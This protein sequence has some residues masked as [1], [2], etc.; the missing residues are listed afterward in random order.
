[1]NIS[2]SGASRLPVGETRRLGMGIVRTLARGAG[3]GLCLGVAGGSGAGQAGQMGKLPG[4]V[5]EQPAVR[6][7]PKTLPS[8]V[9]QPILMRITQIKPQ[10]VLRGG[11]VRITGH[12]FGEAQGQQRARIG[13][14]AITVQRW[15]KELITGTLPGRLSPGQSY[16]V[17]VVDGQGKTLASGRTTACALPAQ[18]QVSPADRTAGSSAGERSSPSVASPPVSEAAR[19]SPPRPPRVDGKALLEEIKERNQPHIGRRPQPMTG[20]ATRPAAVLPSQPGLLQPQPPAP[21]L[22]GVQRPGFSQPSLTPQ[23]E[24]GVGAAPRNI[25]PSPNQT[26]GFGEAA[27]RMKQ[28]QEGAQRAAARPLVGGAELHIN[29]SVGPIVEV[30]AGDPVNVG[31]ST[32]TQIGERVDRLWLVVRESAVPASVCDGNP[33]RSYPPIPAILGDGVLNPPGVT[34]SNPLTRLTPGTAYHIRLCIRTDLPGE[35][36]AWRGVSNP[37]TLNY[38]RLEIEPGTVLGGVPATVVPAPDRGAEVRIN[39]SAGPAVEV[40]AGDPVN[41]S[42]R[43]VTGTYELIDRLWLVV[44]ESALP[45]DACKGNPE[46]TYKESPAINGDGAQSPPIRIGRNTLTGFAP[47]TT[48]YLRLCVRTDQRSPDAGFAWRLFSN[49]LTL[50]YPPAGTPL[51][52]APV[53]AT[54]SL[55]ALKKQQRGGI[56]IDETTTPTCFGQPATIVGTPGDDYLEGTP[57][58]DV[59][60]GLGGNDT[61]EELWGGDDLICGGTGDDRLW[62]SLGNDRLHGGP[63]NDGLDG[64]GGQD[65]LVGGFGNDTLRGGPGND[66]LYGEEG[67]DTLHGGPGDDRLEGGPGDDLLYG[68]PGNDRFLGGFG[69]DT[70]DGTYGT[71]YTSGG[72][73]NTINIDN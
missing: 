13:S 11:L 12:G 44:R 27:V 40:V 15:D 72:C 8:Q 50:H 28:R 57:G 69:T 17:A 24:L 49:P 14:Q 19:L 18:K 47:G 23:T 55:T 62:G 42:W 60:H 48:Y 67:N 21:A 71:D 10:C 33:E 68:G 35:G 41:V 52:R 63:G 61:I 32:V 2:E 3:V 1:M 7:V 37:V 30:V 64:G 31:W 54:E 4:K 6:E 36:L 16:T 39:G 70:C 20:A 73:E 59:I 56:G 34:G 43:I 53:S 5:I 58:D 26:S 45:D 38:R 25:A 9:L 51:A 66:V 22:P 29:D 46:S 65:V